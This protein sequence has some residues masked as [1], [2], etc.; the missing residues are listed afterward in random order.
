MSNCHHGSLEITC[1]GN[2]VVVS[3]PRADVLELVPRTSDFFWEQKTYMTRID[4]F[5][6]TILNHASLS[7]KVWFVMRTACLYS[8]KVQKIMQKGQARSGTFEFFKMW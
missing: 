6:I 2:A 1:C 7:L 5:K 8:A 3:F 4:W